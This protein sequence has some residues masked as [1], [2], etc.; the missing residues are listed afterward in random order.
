M[1]Q[2]EAVREAKH[3]ADRP[4]TQEELEAIEQN[5]AESVVYVDGESIPCCDHVLNT[6][7][8]TGLDELG[9]EYPRE[10]G[11]LRTKFRNLTTF[12]HHSSTSSHVLMQAHSLE[13]KRPAPSRPTLTKK[14]RKS[15][16]EPRSTSSQKS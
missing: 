5:A 11:A 12:F 6:V 1:P 16:Q 13:L 2:K 8:T 7:V 3:E 14:S 15:C 4:L 9:A 10:F